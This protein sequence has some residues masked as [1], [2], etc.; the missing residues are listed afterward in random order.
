MKPFKKTFTKTAKANAIQQKDANVKIEFF[1]I[2]TSLIFLLSLI[3]ISSQ[4]TF[5]FELEKGKNKVHI[6][7]SEPIYVET[8]IKLN[9]EIEAISYSENNRSRGYVN[10]FGGLGENFIVEDREYEII[11]SKNTNLV[12]PD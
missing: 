2:L 8:L 5:S 10:V 9:P 12:L 3:L 6:N 1:L 4:E 11:V 7:S